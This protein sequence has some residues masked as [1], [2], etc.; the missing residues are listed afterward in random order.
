MAAATGK[1]QTITVEEAAE[2]LRI[3]RNLAYELAR[4][5]PP[6]LPGALRLGGR[7]VVSRSK[8]E[9]AINGDHENAAGP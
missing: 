7:I 1:S 3:G 6:E 8:L 9:R 4:R 5:N 2:R